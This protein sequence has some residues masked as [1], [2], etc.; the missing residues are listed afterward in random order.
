[1]PDIS[2]QNRLCSVGLIHFL[3]LATSMH[4]R[5]L[6]V[7][8]AE[9]VPCVNCR[10]CSRSRER[11]PSSCRRQLTGMPTS[12]ATA[13]AAAGLSPDA[14]RTRTPRPWSWRTTAT[15]SG[16]RVAKAPQ[17]ACTAGDQ[18]CYSCGDD[19]LAVAAVAAAG[20]RPESTWRPH[21][22]RWHKHMLV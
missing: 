8:T 22:A 13:A 5:A 10:E 2:A 15:A 9:R 14:S 11:Q 20:L 21:H 16:L 4:V 12:R 3:L 7:G 19:A 18:L 17:V 6:L 1:M